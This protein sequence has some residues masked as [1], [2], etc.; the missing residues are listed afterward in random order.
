M[1]VG[2]LGTSHT[3]PFA[4]V[5]VRLCGLTRKRTG[6]SR[7]S[8]CRLVETADQGATNVPAHD[9]EAHVPIWFTLKI[10]GAEAAGFFKEASGSDS[11]SEIAETKRPKP[12]GHTDVITKWGDI[13]L[14][15]GV[16][17]DKTLW[18]W[19]KMIIDGNLKDARKDCTITLLDYQGQ[20]VVTYSI[21]N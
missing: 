18:N 7:T 11:E 1:V 8:R 21:T 5:M 9:K 13:E 19:R 4:R 10:G 15:R 2:T 20:P 14:K 17:Q 6:P 3:L 16:D 12:D